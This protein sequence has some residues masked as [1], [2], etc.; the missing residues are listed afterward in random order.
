[1]MVVVTVMVTMEAM[2]GRKKG[3]TEERTEGRK[4]GRKGYKT[5]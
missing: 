3:N 1:M 2:G 4:A 5:K